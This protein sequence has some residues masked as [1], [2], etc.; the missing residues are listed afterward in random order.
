MSGSHDKI[1]GKAI[2]YFRSMN[3]FPVSKLKAPKSS[4]DLNLNQTPDLQL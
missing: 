4:L 1:S 3:I 2:V